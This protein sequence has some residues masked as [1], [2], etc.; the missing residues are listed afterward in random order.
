MVVGKGSG[1]R[2]LGQDFRRL[3]GQ[4]YISTRMDEGRTMSDW[5]SFG[6]ELRGLS[7]KVSVLQPTPEAEQ[8]VRDLILKLIAVLSKLKPR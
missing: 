5:D 6:A 8:E 2:W 3:S 1:A 4:Q 7:A